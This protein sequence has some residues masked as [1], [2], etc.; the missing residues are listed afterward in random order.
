VELNGKHVVR[1]GW[2]IR[3]RRSPASIVTTPDPNSPRRDWKLG[4]VRG[5]LEVATVID[6]QIAHGTQISHLIVLCA[7]I[8]GI[9][10]SALTI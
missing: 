10:L 2:P 6:P 5:V 4:D 8:A 1:T 3:C 9:L 7:I